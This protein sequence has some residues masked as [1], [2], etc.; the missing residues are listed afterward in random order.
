MSK[1]AKIHETDSKQEITSTSEGEQ[2]EDDFFYNGF[3]KYW[4]KNVLS[5]GFNNDPN[6]I[7]ASLCVAARLEPKYFTV[8]SN[9]KNRLLQCQSLMKFIN[10]N[11][12]KNPMQQP[13]WVQNAMSTLETKEITKW[14]GQSIASEHVKFSNILQ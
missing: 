13:P 10:D 4:C 2:S 14:N 8:H 9:H 5:T 12:L 7:C 1:F 11:I 3:E 6:M